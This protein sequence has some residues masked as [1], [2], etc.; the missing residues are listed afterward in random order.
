[1]S[2][3]WKESREGSFVLP[4]E[5]PETFELYLHWLYSKKLPVKRENQCNAEYLALAKAVALGD[6]LQDFD[7]ADAAVDAIIDK[8]RHSGVIGQELDTM[9]K[10]IYENT[11]EGFKARRLF[12]DFYMCLDEPKVPRDLPPEF[13]LDLVTV[14]LPRRLGTYIFDPSTMTNTC[15]YHNHCPK[16]SL[17][18]KNKFVEELMFL[19]TK[20]NERERKKYRLSSRAHRIQGPSGLQSLINGA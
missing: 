11:V 12:V 16:S 19:T 5:D 17:C 7:F 6:K 10:Y 9:V 4:D 2:S 20:Q 18:Y 14:L 15:R 3:D 1:M 8:S 13:L